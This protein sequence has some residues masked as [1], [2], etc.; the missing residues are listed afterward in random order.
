MSLDDV[1]SQ[2]SKRFG[3]AIS[4]LFE[5]DEVSNPGCHNVFLDGGQGTFALSTSEEELWRERESAGW[6][7]SS[8]VA[9]HVTVTPSKVAV[10]RWDD[11]ANVAVFNRDSIDRKLDE[12]YKFIATDRIRSTRSVVYH[13][14]NLF[15][16]IRSLAVSAGVPDARS[17]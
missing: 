12:F 7:W 1:P 16:R 11:P 10:V 13:L 2:W 8:D 3:L 6:A 17:S 4:P 15:R 14:I 5:R 9:H